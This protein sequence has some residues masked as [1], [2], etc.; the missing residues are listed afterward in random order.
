[1]TTIYVEA[2]DGGC[3]IQ[4]VSVSVDVNTKRMSI[5]AIFYHRSCMHWLFDLFGGLIPADRTKMVGVVNMWT[6]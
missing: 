1:M 4:C 3:F 5:W 2:I 6:S